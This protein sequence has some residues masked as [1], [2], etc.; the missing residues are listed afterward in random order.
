MPKRCVGQLNFMDAAVS[1][2]PQGRLSALDEIARLVDWAAFE[3]LLSAIPIAKKGEPSYPPLVTFKVLSM[4]LA[5][6][7][8]RGPSSMPRWS[9]RGAAA[10]HGRR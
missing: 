9:K 4:R 2:R 5:S 6:L 10:A 3:R 7:L 1:Q 8:N